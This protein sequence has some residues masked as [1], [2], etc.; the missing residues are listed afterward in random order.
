MSMVDSAQS[1]QLWGQ[2]C[3]AF[4]RILERDSNCAAARSG[5]GLGLLALGDAKEACAQ[6]QSATRLEPTPDHVCNLALGLM[7]TGRE[8]EADLLLSGVLDTVPQH[9][10]ARTTLAWLREKRQAVSFAAS[11]R[12]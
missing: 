3:T 2:V 6:L 11:Q 10:A 7:H 9:Q 5:L 12:G 8:V 4:I 1:E